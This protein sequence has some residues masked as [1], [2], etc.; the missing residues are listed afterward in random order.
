MKTLTRNENT[1]WTVLSDEQMSNGWPFSLL[2]DEQ[3]S[4]KVGVEHQPAEY[5]G[6]GLE[7]N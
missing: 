2:N 5:H 6:G 3:M 4:N 7:I 1:D